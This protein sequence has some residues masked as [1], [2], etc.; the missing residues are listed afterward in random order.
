MIMTNPCNSELKQLIDS[1]L[2]INLTAAFFRYP[3]ETEV[4]VVAQKSAEES[5]FHTLDD[6][7]TYGFV[8]APFNS[9]AD[10]LPTVVIRPDITDFTALKCF[11]NETKTTFAPSKSIQT[12]DVDK[13]GYLRMFQDV[14]SQFGA[15]V[16]KVVLARSITKK[17]QCPVPELF[18]EL[19]G[20][21]TDRMVCLVHTPS[22]GTWLCATPELL[23]SGDNGNYATMALAGT[24]RNEGSAAWDNKN[25]AEH[26][27]VCH[28]FD[29]RLSGCSNVQHSAHYTIDFGILQHLRTDYTFHADNIAPQRLAANLHPTPAV[30]GRPV[31]KAMKVIDTYELTNRAYYSGVIGMLSEKSCSLFINLR[32]AYVHDGQITTFAGGGLMPDSEAESEWRETEMKMLFG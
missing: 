5:T 9:S 26:E 25:I 28:H 31:D 20:D 19:L 22:T 24:R 2:R 30:C 3:H 4:H 14:T 10:G 8:V 16:Q 15:D 12:V 6:I 13:Q 11:L 7:D 21:C 29:E 17:L 32:C 27:V 18:M 23:L 1:A